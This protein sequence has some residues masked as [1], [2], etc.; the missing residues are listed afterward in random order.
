M[1]RR[2]IIRNLSPDPVIYFTKKKELSVWSG[3]YKILVS[4]RELFM[5]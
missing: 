2:A 5:S 3:M 4:G 1:E